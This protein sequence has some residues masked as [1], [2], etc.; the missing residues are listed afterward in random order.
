[1]TSVNDSKERTLDPEVRCYAFGVVLAVP[2]AAVSRS[3]RSGR[4]GVRKLIFVC[5]LVSTLY[6]CFY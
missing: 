6:R 5:S 2:F 1:M 4:S 3:G